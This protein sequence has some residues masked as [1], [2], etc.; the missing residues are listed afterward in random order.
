MARGAGLVLLTIGLLL[1]GYALYDG[2]GG[3]IYQMFRGRE[4]DREIES[5]PAAPATAPPARGD[6]YRRGSAIGRLEIPRLGLSEVVFEGSDTHTLRLGIGRLSNSALPGDPG[7]VVLA[8]HRD[9]FFRP[10]REIRPGDEI[11]LRTREGTFSYTVGW[12]KVVKPTDVS[13]IMPTASPALT[14]VT[15]YPFYYIGSAPE[16]FIVR[17]APAAEV[18][19]RKAP[20]SDKPSPFT[21]ARRRFAQPA[22]ALA[23]PVQQSAAAPLPA[24]PGEPV[25]DPLPRPAQP[26]AL[27]RAWHKLANVFSPHRDT[28]E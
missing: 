1:T 21:P 5:V 10:L 22:V 16:R 12:T 26:G 18:S 2:F 28:L 9:T 25:T 19:A 11:W 15:C 8:G 7:N 27:K 3:R 17:A 14:L 23:A 13:L 6:R 24:P 4:L 20:V